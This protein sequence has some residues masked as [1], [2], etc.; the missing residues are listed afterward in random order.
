MGNVVITKL[1]TVDQPGYEMGFASFNLNKSN[2][3]PKSR[4]EFILRTIELETNI[5]EQ[6]STS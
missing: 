3:Y 2:G 4:S 6:E 5:I 1:N